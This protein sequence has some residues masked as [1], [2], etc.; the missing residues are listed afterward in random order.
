MDTEHVN[1]AL[2]MLLFLAILSFN[3]FTQVLSNEN[4]GVT[5]LDELSFEKML[6]QFDHVLVKFDL[7][8]PE[9][10]SH[11]AYG[12]LAKQ[13]NDSHLDNLL[14][15]EVRVKDYG[16]KVKQGPMDLAFRFSVNTAKE[17][18]PELILFSFGKEVARFT[19]EKKSLGELRQFLISNAGVW[20]KKPGS[21]REL[22]IMAGEYIQEDD[23]EG[24]RWVL[25]DAEEIAKGLGEDAAEYIKLMKAALEE[26]EPY[27][28]KEEIRVKGLLRGKISVEK[29][30]KFEKRI[31]II[32]S[33][34]RNNWKALPKVDRRIRNKIVNENPNHYEL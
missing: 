22:D 25:E 24:R 5:Q 20:I 9:Y 7:S 26:G 29:K 34:R 8:N 2:E 32:E 11:K 19:G 17:E 30:A 15:A 31:N 12:E 23:E 27:I 10:W 28:E 33:F 1:S 6:S 18:L 13:A 21:V 3:I 4:E 14:M 16:G